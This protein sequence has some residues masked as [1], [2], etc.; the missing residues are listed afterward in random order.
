LHHLPSDPDEA[1]NLLEGAEGKARAALDRL[2]EAAGQFPKVD[3]IP[4]YTAL[5]A[6]PWDK[7][8]A[9]V[10]SGGE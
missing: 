8:P 10:Q 1:I 9:R 2:V 5:P 7:Q 6:Q 4:R 3:A